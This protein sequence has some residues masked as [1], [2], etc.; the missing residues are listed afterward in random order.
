MSINH[1][2]ETY[3]FCKEN[4]SFH[5]F[6][7]GGVLCVFGASYGRPS[8]DVEKKGKSAGVEDAHLFVQISCGH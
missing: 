6:R 3:K 4:K 7:S 2:G 8:H 5:G 1:K